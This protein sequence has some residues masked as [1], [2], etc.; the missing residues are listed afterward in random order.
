[1]MPTVE[2]CV[3]SSF[4]FQT[5]LV[6][7]PI[8]IRIKDQAAVARDA[9]EKKMAAEEKRRKEEARAS[10]SGKDKTGHKAHHSSSA[11]SQSAASASLMALSAT[12]SSSFFASSPSFL[13]G[14]SEEAHA[15]CQQ[16]EAVLSMI[17]KTPQINE[18]AVEAIMKSRPAHIRKQQAII[19]S[20]LNRKSDLKLSGMGMGA[21]N[22]KTKVKEAENEADK[23]E[24]LVEDDL[25]FVLDVDADGADAKITKKA[26]K[27]KGKKKADGGLQGGVNTKSSRVSS[28]RDELLR[29]GVIL[30]QRTELLRDEVAAQARL[31]RVIEEEK[32]KELL[33]KKERDLILKKEMRQLEES[34]R[35][36]VGDLNK[37]T[38]ELND[39][40]KK[41]D[42]LERQATM[43]A[44]F[45]DVMME[46]IALTRR[47][48]NAKQKQ[49]QL[50]IDGITAEDEE[51]AG[52]ATRLVGKEDKEREKEKEKKKK[53]KK[54]KE[55]DKEQLMKGFGLGGIVGRGQKQIEVEIKLMKG[56]AETVRRTL[57]SKYVA[58]LGQLWELV[59][60][61]ITSIPLPF[62][63]NAASSASASSSTTPSTSMALPS[64]LPQPL[65]E[66]LSVGF[67]DISKFSYPTLMASLPLVSLLPN[68]VSET[69]SFR[70][71]IY[72]PPPAAMAI[73]DNFLADP[74]R[75]LPEFTLFVYRYFDLAPWLLFVSLVDWMNDE[76]V[77]EAI[78]EEER[79]NMGI[80]P[81]ATTSTA[82]LSAAAARLKARKVEDA[83]KR[84]K[85]G[86]Q[87]IIRQFLN[88]SPTP[89]GSTG[90]ALSQRKYLVPGSLAALITALNVPLPALSMHFARNAHLDYTL[91]AVIVQT[92][93]RAA[94]LGVFNETEAEETFTLPYSTLRTSKAVAAAAAAS[95]SLTPFTTI[96]SDWEVP[97]VEYPALSV[98]LSQLATL[99][100]P[101]MFVLFEALR[102][103]VLPAFIGTKSFRKIIRARMEEGAFGVPVHQKAGTIWVETN[104]SL[105][106][107]K[108]RKKW[109]KNGRM[110]TEEEA[111]ETI[112]KSSKQSA[113]ATDILWNVGKVYDMDD[114]TFKTD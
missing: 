20:L 106:E 62:E 107:R 21:L 50:L 67:V 12:H 37:L 10:A 94:E 88:L 113:D 38:K 48:M 89:A 92:L 80:A 95:K 54:A 91:R 105:A 51:R 28:K 45:V 22:S 42:D 63:S 43:L 59:R 55:G 30:Q 39:L 36:S 52:R 8:S 4:L 112:Q 97:N 58:S 84:M 102:G 1:M 73:L 82:A 108:E 83:Q 14:V 103:L 90:T 71:K 5:H 47:E 46:E 79:A 100:D 41:R 61:Y 24:V 13:P 65:A 44:N 6:S 31:A 27:G 35:Q 57:H 87:R 77:L 3:V 17:M 26:K 7:V 68:R 60:P 111:R 72:V 66:L 29:L 104:A 75:A 25:D 23:P 96:L 76:M 86:A 56:F 11:T 101:L 70:S 34:K 16:E 2:F 81:E 49:L 18:S 78:Q 69:W 40:V 85:Q 53:K 98:P 93:R 99:F 64:T 110:M 114:I 15:L 109:T 33:K 32:K 74:R 19:A 9:A